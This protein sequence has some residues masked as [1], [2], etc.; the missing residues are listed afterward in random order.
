MI[1]AAIPLHFMCVVNPDA[2][3]EDAIELLAAEG[4]GCASRPDPEKLNVYLHSVGDSIAV[5]GPKRTTIALVRRPLDTLE[6]LTAVQ[7]AARLAALH[8]E[9]EASET[10]LEIGRALG[11]ERDML[12]LQ[13]LILRRAREL[14]NADAGSLL[15]VEEHGGEKKL[16]FAVAQTGPRDK[17]THIGATLPLTASSISGSVALHGEVARIRDAYALG[18]AS[19]YRFDSSFDKRTGYRTKSVLCVPMRNYRGEV[20]GVIQ[21]INRKPTFE[22]VLTS[23]EQTVEVV[24]DFDARDERVAMALAAQAGV[25]LENSRLIENIQ[26]LFENFVRASVKAIEVRDV[27]TQG[28]SERVSRLTVAQAE[29]VNAIDAGPLRELNFTP[30]RLQ[31]LRYAAL[32]HD[33]G[34]LSVPEYIFSK[35]KKLPDGRLETI[36]M[37]FYLALEQIDAAAAREKFEVL[38][39]NSGNDVTAALS[40]VDARREQAREELL[41]LLQGVEKAN[42]PAIVDAAVD[43]ALTKVMQRHYRLDG[44]S[45]PLLDEAELRYLHIPRGSLSDEERDLMNL[46]V[47]NSFRF[48]AA[49]PWSTT[50]WPGVA[51][52]AYSHHEHLDGT[53][54]PRKLTA[55]EIPPPV[56]MLTIADVFDALTASDRPYKKAVPLQKALDILTKEFAERGKIDPI[57]LDVFIQKRL[58]EAV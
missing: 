39:G 49:L 8:R 56:R 36:R 10:L 33:F 5:T 3:A 48:L 41:M 2:H 17:G 11:A 35:A 46:H 1:D 6:L 44:T 53:G 38:R 45:V 55:D 27:S 23:P 40:G 24:H 7:G 22:T 18:E 4:I 32:L 16:R 20:V 31:E 37:R 28:H 19:P 29:A 57:F 15:L 47:T 50:P 30:E 14:T 25:A 43:E 12:S 54:Y 58:Y 9:A 52:I 42:E 13:Q 34:K 51:H 21:L 26:G